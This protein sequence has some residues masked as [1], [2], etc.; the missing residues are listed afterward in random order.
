MGATSGRRK[1][2]TTH[3]VGASCSSMSPLMKVAM[4]PAAALV[5]SAVF[6]IVSLFIS[7]SSTLT[8]FWFSLFCVVGFEGA[9]SM[10]STE[11]IMCS[12]RERSERKALW[13]GGG[14]KKVIG[15]VC[16]VQLKTD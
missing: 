10:M 2:A 15:D 6:E 13:R 11:G 1:G 4:L 12:E 14:K 9:A 8:D 3:L 16:G 5:S 7:S